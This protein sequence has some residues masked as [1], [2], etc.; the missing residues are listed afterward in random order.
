MCDEKLPAVKEYKATVKL[1]PGS[2][3]IN[4]KARTIPLH[5]QDWFTEKL[6]TMVRQSILESVQSEGVTNASAVDWQ[7]KCSSKTM[8]G[9]ESLHYRQI[10]GRRGVSN[11]KHLIFSMGRFVLEKFNYQTHIIKSNLT[12]MQKRLCNQHIAMVFQDIQFPSSGLKDF[13]VRLPRFHRIN[14]QG[15]K[16][17]VIFQADVLSYGTTKEQYE[18]RMLAVNSRLSEI[19][20]TIHKKKSQTQPILCVNFLAY[21]FSKKG[22]EPG[23]KHDVEVKNSKVPS[24]QKQLEYC[25]G[26]A[27]FLW[28]NDAKICCNVLIH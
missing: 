3:P 27:K 14:S 17:S 15:I 12:S 25:V 6:E 23:P 24:N 5:L 10:Y 26:T 1:K 16:G 20:F 21:S 11:S 22:I 2:Q 8:R 7:Q 13:F 19:N 9:P 28:L 4:G 18:K